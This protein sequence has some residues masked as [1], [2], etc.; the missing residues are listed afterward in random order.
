MQS[1]K[2]LKFKYLYFNL[3]LMLDLNK[4]QGTQDQT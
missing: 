3:Y 2:T 4:K 1:E